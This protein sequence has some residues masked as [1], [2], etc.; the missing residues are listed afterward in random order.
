MVEGEG[1]GEEGVCWMIYALFTELNGPIQ[2]NS[3]G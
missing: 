1:E 3:I 2:C